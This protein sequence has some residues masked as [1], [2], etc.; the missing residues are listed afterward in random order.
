M[1]FVSKEAVA[2]PQPQ[3]PD[4]ANIYRREEDSK[5][6]FFPIFPFFRPPPPLPVNTGNTGNTATSGNQYGGYLA[7]GNNAQAGNSK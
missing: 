6:F 7:Y 5:D 2:L 1:L 3:V 4:T